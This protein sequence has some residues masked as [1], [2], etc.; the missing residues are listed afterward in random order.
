MSTSLLIIAFAAGILSFLSPCIVPMLGVY[1]S[2]IT[3]MTASELREN[4]LDPHLR[5]R[6][7][8][9]TLAFV[10]G[11]G[12][13]FTAAGALAAQMGAILS[14]WQGFLN[15]LGGTVVLILALKLLGVFDLPFLS[16]LHWEP[17]FFEK[18][19]TKATRSAWSSFVV[20]LLFAIACSHCIAPTLLS[21]LT[22]AGATKDAFSGMIVMAIFSLGLAIPYVLAGLS[23]NRV[24]SSL[25]KFRSRQYVAER[26]AGV[27]ML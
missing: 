14:K 16:R 22:M 19:R 4:A 5:V 3:G 9:N 2:L 1:F 12:L 8:K 26:I 18:L 11:F 25:K 7:I 21:I 27:L 10:A 15:A 24:I 6:V 23:F 17:A 20:G 13:V